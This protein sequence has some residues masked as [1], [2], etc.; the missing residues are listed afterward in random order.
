MRSRRDICR[1]AASALQGGRETIA[2]ANAVIGFDGFVDEI[3]SVVEKRSA[4]GS[5]QP[6]P[7]IARLAEKMSAAAGKSSNYE[8]LVQETRLGGNG[9]IMSAA[10]AGFGVPVT[11][12]G[13]LGFPRLHPVFSDLA[14]R[15]RVLGIAP[16]AHTDAL[17]FA[18]GKLMLGKLEGL[19]EVTWNNIMGRVGDSEF[20]GLLAAAQLIGMLNWTMIPQMSDIWSRLIEDVLPKL[21]SGTTAT[22]ASRRR[23]LFVDLADPEKRTKDDLT[24]A[25]RLL[26]RLQ[27]SADVILGLN[28]KEAQQTCAAL[29]QPEPSGSLDALAKCAA[30]ICE[31]LQI[32]CC[33][34]HPRTGAAGATAQAQRGFAG[35]FVHSPAIS[36]GAGDHFNAGF[37]LGRLLDLPLEECLCTGVATSGYYVRRR[38]SPDL[39]QLAQFIQNMPEPE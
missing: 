18:D 35:P 19:G 13:A 27:D 31:S 37:V 29:G 26:S 16:P 6:V 15:A 5:I 12:I 34:I 8:L 9:P 1:D 23:M 38:L 3:C 32:D 20:S 33:V 7:T 24:H 30:R 22:R 25:L 4:S 17:E 21:S 2:Q 14:R 36:T 11:C 28:L 10:L 39:A